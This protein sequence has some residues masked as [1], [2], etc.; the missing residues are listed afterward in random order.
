MA[1]DINK[2]KGLFDRAYNNSMLEDKATGVSDEK[3]IREYCQKVFGDGSATPDPSSL[4]QF[5][6]ILVQ[7]ADMLAKGMMPNLLDIFAEFKNETPGNIY[8]YNVPVKTKAK[9]K[10]AATGTGVDL[11]RV[12]G[13]KKTVAVPKVFQT[14]FYYEPTDMTQDSVENYRKLVDDLANAKIK[15]YF[16]Q[17][18]KLVASAI[19]S[20]KIPTKNVLSGADTTLAN[21]NKTASILARVGMGGKPVF[22]ADTLLIDYYANQQYTDTNI[23]YIIP[24]N[25]KAELLNSLTIT[26][27]GRTTAINLAN[28]FTDDTN[29]ATELPVNEG[30]MFN[31][32]VGKKPFIIVEYGGMRQI[33]EQDPEDERIKMIIK[34][35][36]AVELI[37]GAALG[38]IK[39]TNTSK[40]GL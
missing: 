1:Y 8:A 3:D 12:E 34:Q 31:S 17:V 5:N 6:T 19:S 22:V 7:Q 36:A 21:F 24:E 20:G 18:Q 14:G 29:S 10:W 26:Q 33:T 32:A 40:V 23:K 30:Y 11:V 35:D 38:F 2:L 16:A 27:I 39:E 9:F 25:V 28:P 37:Y 13:G 15:L 4:H